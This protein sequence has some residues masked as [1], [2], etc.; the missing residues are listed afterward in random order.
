MAIKVDEAVLEEW[1]LHLRFRRHAQEVLARRHAGEHG[2]VA[3]RA[4]RN[5]SSIDIRPNSGDLRLC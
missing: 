5:G 4:H 2:L 3:P 1:R